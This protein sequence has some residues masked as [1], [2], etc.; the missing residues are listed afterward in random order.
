[1]EFRPAINQ[2][3]ILNIELEKFI[4][5]INEAGFKAVELRTEKIREYLNS[6][7]EHS[8]EKLKN[9][10]DSFNIKVL[11]LNALENFSISSEKVF[12]SEVMKIFG[13]MIE[14]C[15]ALDCHLIISVPSFFNM[16]TQNPSWDEIRDKTAKRLEILGEITKKNNVK[17]GFEPL[18]FTDCS[19]RTIKQAVEILEKLNPEIDNIGIVIDTCH[20]FVAYNPIS[21]IELIKDLFLIHVNDLKCDYK[22]DNLS[23]VKDSDRIMPGNGNFPF[24]EFF[25]TI[26][27][28]LEYHGYISIELFNE[29]YWEQNPLD[30]AKKAM[31]S[32]ENIK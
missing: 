13:E 1:M 22:H 11:S 15:N 8:L 27:K 6:D 2:A 28:K 20:F 16:N 21:S 19:V 24:R 17:I 26:K 18:G 12:N 3:T 29:S 10:L 23:W 25:E 31:Q 14:Y 30:V 9:L 32:F 5:S 4:E 7:P